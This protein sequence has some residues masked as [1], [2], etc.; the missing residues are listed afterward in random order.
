MHMTLEADYAVRIVACLVT[1]DQRRDAAYIAEKTQVPLRFALKILRKLVQGRLAVSFK[2]AR[3]GYCLA[4]PAEEI[5]LRQVIELVEGPYRLSR[6]VRG[7]SFCP[8]MPD[9]RFSAVYAEIADAVREKL[10]SYTFA[11]L[12][13]GPAGDK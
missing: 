6:C 1:E 10:E 7:D 5:T 8:R 2:G 9:C 3:G 12:C 13:A 11:G 4:R